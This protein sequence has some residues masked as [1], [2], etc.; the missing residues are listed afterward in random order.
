[1]SECLIF[2][3]PPRILISH[4][5]MHYAYMRAAY[6]LVFCSVNHGN[7]VQRMYYYYYYMARCCAQTYYKNESPSAT[8]VFFRNAYR[9]HATATY[10][11]NN[12]IIFVFCRGTTPMRIIIYIPTYYKRIGI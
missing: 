12:I 1:V 5:P 4:C 3:E 2:K 11:Y 8:I 7:S 6:T 9:S 10:R